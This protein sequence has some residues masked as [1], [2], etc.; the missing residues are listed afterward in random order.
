MFTFV[1]G[2]VFNYNTFRTTV[3]TL[4]ITNLLFVYF[5]MKVQVEDYY[6]PYTGKPLTEDEKALFMKFKLNL[7]IG[8]LVLFLMSH[9]FGQRD[10]ITYAIKNNM[11][12]R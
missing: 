12:S 11:I 3:L 9:Y 4:P 6:N 1:A 2:F 5:Q 10:L 7:L 8:F